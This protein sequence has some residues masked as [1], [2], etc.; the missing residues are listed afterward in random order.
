[1]SNYWAG[2]YESIEGRLFDL[3]TACIDDLEKEYARATEEIRQRIDSFYARFA[4]NNE[5]SLVEAQKML[6][7]KELQEFKW[8]LEE[9]TRYAKENVLSERWVK[10]LENASIRVRIERLQA[11][12]VQIRQQLE[13]LYANREQGLKNLLELVYEDGYYQSLYE[14]QKYEGMGYSFQKLSTEEIK[15]VISKAWAPDGRNFSDRIWNDRNL[16]INTFH[17]ELVRSLIIGRGLQETSKVLSERMGVSK[18]NAMRLV[19]T[20]SNHYSNA[21]FQAS[22]KETGVDE[23]IFVA[24]LDMKTSTICRDMDGKIIRTSDIKQGVNAPTLHTNCRSVMAPY[25][26]GNI[27]ERAARGKDGKTYKVDG[28]ITYKEW[29]KK[30]V[31][32]N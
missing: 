28:N 7:I 2:R 32:N 3:G 11:L 13:V 17:Q 10:E 27:I 4:T 1:M 21:S 23:Q 9:Y 24:T 25:Y 29:Y 18:R 6:T 16:L 15:K 22:F 8:S 26:E 31:E 20:E 14:M 12:E 5:V 19:R 30:Y